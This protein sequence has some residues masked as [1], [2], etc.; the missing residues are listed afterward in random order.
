MALSGSSP[1]PPTDATIAVLA[2]AADG[3]EFDPADF[4]RASKGLI[5]QL[6][7]GQIRSAEGHLTWDVHRH[8]FIREH[9]S[10]PDS[11]HPSLWRQAQLNAIHGLFAVDSGLWQVRGY[12][13]SNISFIEGDTGWIVIDPLTTESTAAAAL[14][15]INATLGERPVTAVI[16]TH[17]HADHFGGVLGVTSAHAAAAGDVR[18][19]AP[20]HFLREAVFENVI[21]G[22]AMARRAAYQ[23]GA[24]LPAG[25]RQHVD[26]GLGKAIPTAGAGLLAPTEEITETGQELMVDG[27]RIVFQLTPETEA[28]AEMNFFF[29]DRRWLCMAENCSH[30][31]HN[32]VPMRGAQVRD[33]LAWS[34][35][36]GESIELFGADT[37]IMFA[38]HHWPRWGTDDVAGFLRRQRDLYRWMHDQTMRLAN[39][40]LTPTEIAEELTLAESFVHHGDTRGYYGSLVH[41]VK[42]VYQRYLSW[43][44]ANPTNLWRHT[45]SAAGTR[46]AAMV[47]GVDSLVGHAQRAF[48]AGDYRWAAELANHAVF[49]DPTHAGARALQADT[50]E[51]LGYQSESATWR[52]AYLTGAHELRHGAPPA[53]ATNRGGLVDALTV[54]LLFDAVAVRLRAEDVAGQHVVINWDFTDVN[55]KWILGLE[56]QALH[57]VAGRHQ[58][59]AAATVRMTRQLLAAI[60]GGHTTFIDAVQQGDIVIDGEASAL[61]AIFGNLETFMSGFA[62]VEP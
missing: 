58:V 43:Y 24:N 44:D 41:N 1:K 14:A 57:Y 11:V 49:A 10:C 54:D 42:A 6:D 45:P 12:D 33:A 61:L 52:N 62:I 7:T 32:L 39:R 38:S 30:N 4:E 22:P 50:L 55:E 27:V 8:D 47:G 5:A 51:Q 35:Y 9:Q 3:I 56:N 13:I 37:T 34:K 26:S 15:L 36:I 21:G 19:I 29:P 28:P 46:Y 18:I 25:P 31:M 17:S 60:L 16:Y 40:G 23:F 48:A 20:E 2:N 53:R 59:D